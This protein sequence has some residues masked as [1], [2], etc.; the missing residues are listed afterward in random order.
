VARRATKD[1]YGIEVIGGAEV[2]RLVKAGDVIPSTYAVADG[3]FEEVN[4]D[5]QTNV[6]DIQGVRHTFGT[7]TP[8]AEAGARADER[9]REALEASAG[10]QPPPGS[11][12]VPQRSTDEL[13]GEALESAGREAGHPKL[14][15][16]PWSEL[17]ADE[18]RQAL[19]QG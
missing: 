9:Q 7:D 17:S 13:K 5:R 15:D 1:T 14:G 2:R 19:A 3:T 6:G 16:T 11:G 18:K 12:Q 4:I 8:A 10:V